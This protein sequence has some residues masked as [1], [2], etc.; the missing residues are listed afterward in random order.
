M[1]KK[2]IKILVVG[3]IFAILAGVFTYY[4]QVHSD[5]NKN[6]AQNNKKTDQDLNV[7]DNT[8]QTKPPEKGDLVAEIDTTKGVIKLKLFPE[9]APKAVENFQSLA[10]ENYYD[11]IIFHRVINNFMI[12]GGDPTGTGMGG[13]SS[14]GKPF[15]DEFSPDLKNIRGAVSMANSGKNTNGSQFFIVQAKATDWLDGVHTVFGQVYEGMDTVDAIAA[16]QVDKNSKPLEDIKM[17]SVKVYTL[18]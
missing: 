3:V 5:N 11:G 2:E 6:T 4:L 10:D 18:E 15:E 14:F 12:Q 8:M 1:N 7:S 17:N 13:Q 16:T 9:Q